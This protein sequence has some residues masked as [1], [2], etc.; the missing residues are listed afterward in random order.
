MQ[1]NWV[2]KLDRYKAE[3]K[4]LKKIKEKALV[5][6]TVIGDPDYKTSLKIIKI[7]AEKG[8]ILELGIPFSDP[9]AD[10]STIQKADVRALKQSFNTNKIFDFL[11]KVRIFT[12]KPIGLLKHL[13]KIATNEGDVVLDPF[14]GVGSTGVASLQMGRRF[15]GIEIEKEY[16]DAA[17]V[18]IKNI[19]PDM[20]SIYKN[21]LTE[22]RI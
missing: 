3:F 17:K 18:R 5:P 12:Q 4:K 16:F 8:D 21:K 1:K 9:I 10:G 19:Q 13:I 15:I 7:L 20:F 14:M 22:R 6:F 11:K 2:L